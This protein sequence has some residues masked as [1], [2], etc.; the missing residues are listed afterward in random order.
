MGG[1][2]LGC[3]A[4][5]RMMDKAPTPQPSPG[6]TQGHCACHICAVTGTAAAAAAPKKEK[7]R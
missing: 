1:D 6:A 2:M 4:G 7:L 3:P 5:L